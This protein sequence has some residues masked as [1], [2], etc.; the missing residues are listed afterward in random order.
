M[1]FEPNAVQQPLAR[2]G[3]LAL[4]GGFPCVFYLLAAALLARL[5]LYGG[6]APA[7]APGQ[8][9]EQRERA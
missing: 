1:A 7:F 8:L 6:D 2:A 5:S 4:F 9:A 3:I